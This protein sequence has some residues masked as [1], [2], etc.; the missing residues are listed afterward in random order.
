MTGKSR[1]RWVLFAVAGVVLALLLGFV[2]LPLSIPRPQPVR[3]VV[4]DDYAA[5]DVQT[6]R[7]TAAPA[8][9]AQPLPE[10][11]ELPAGHDEFWD[12]AH[13]RADW[14]GGATVTCDV[15]ALMPDRPARVFGNVASAFLD[16]DQGVH[17]DAAIDVVSRF[18]T[19]VSDG[20]ITF[21]V[22]EPSGTARILLPV[23]PVGEDGEPELSNM[24]GTWGKVRW[25]GAETGTT[26]ACDG[27]WEEPEGRLQVSL[28][29]ERG[30]PLPPRSADGPRVLAVLRGCGFMVPMLEPS[31]PAGIDV[32]AGRCGLQI[33]RRS[34]TFPSSSAAARP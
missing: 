20:R 19:P 32:P 1:L 5:T 9:V 7:P 11:Q 16:M 18:N 24:Q 26:V 22:Q 8:P 4:M 33:E 31:Q 17:L 29:D 13:D 28:L 30:G 12:R 6:F 3:A 23:E 14:I 25:S 21:T 10:R 34:S 15:S 27:V 2:A